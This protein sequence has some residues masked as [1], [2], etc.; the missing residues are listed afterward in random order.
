MLIEEN[1]DKFKDVNAVDGMINKEPV[2][3]LR[4]VGI[5]KADAFDNDGEP[6]EEPNIEGGDEGSPNNPGAEQ[7]GEEG[8]LGAT[9]GGQQGNGQIGPPN[10]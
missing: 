7:G 10:G 8:G 5:S 2:V 4:S 1:P 9:P 6:I 3:D